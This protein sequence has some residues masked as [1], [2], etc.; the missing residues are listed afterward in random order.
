MTR[1]SRVTQQ[2]VALS[3]AL[4]GSLPSL[5]LLILLSAACAL[6][7]PEFLGASNLVNVLRQ[8]SPLFIAAAG[9][10]I[11]VLVGGIDISTGAVVALASVCGALIAA[12]YGTELGVLAAVGVGALAGITS[13]WAVSMF[14]VQP[15]I[16]TIGMLSVARGFAFLFSDGLPISGL[17]ASFIG[18]GNGHVLGVPVPV[19]LALIVLAVMAA[20]LR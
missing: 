9:Q 8:A 19:I 11:V 2:A 1:S 17:P 15:V 13:G 3:A 12:S 18:L 7:A 14:R 16:A 10:M 6:A 20:C 4:Q 5:L